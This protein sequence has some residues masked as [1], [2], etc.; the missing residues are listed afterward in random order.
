M[1]QRRLSDEGKLEAR[2][3]WDD[4]LERKFVFPLVVP[5]QVSCYRETSLAIA[6]KFSCVYMCICVQADM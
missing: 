3:G 4:R 5:H 2:V 1:E 6:G